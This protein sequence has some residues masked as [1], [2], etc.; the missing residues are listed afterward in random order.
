MNSAL[1]EREKEAN[2][3]RYQPRT[4]MQCSKCSSPIM[5]TKGGIWRVSDHLGYALL[6]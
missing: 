1:Q 4:Q 3:Q 6:T 5:M 2:R